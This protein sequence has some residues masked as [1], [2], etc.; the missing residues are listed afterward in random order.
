MTTFFDATGVSRVT[1]GSRVMVRG[2]EGVYDVLVTRTFLDI[3]TGAAVE[4]I[5]LRGKSGKTWERVPPGE[6][7]VCLEFFGEYYAPVSYIGDDFVPAIGT[8]VLTWSDAFK[9]YLRC[10]VVANDGL[11]VKVRYGKAISERKT[12]E[13]YVS[14]ADFRDA[15]RQL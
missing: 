12:S 9:Q 1:V 5:N 13:C 4:Y 11:I 6:V 15:T 14:L 7:G 3:S 10:E 8:F 2:I